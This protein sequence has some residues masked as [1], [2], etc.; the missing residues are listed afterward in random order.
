M[1]LVTKGGDLM[2]LNEKEIYLIKRRRLGITLQE[3]ADC[4]G[5][6]K[7]TL[8]RYENN[9]INFSLADKYKKYIDNK[10]NVLIK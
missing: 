9:L 2:H 5:V 7:G 1:Q 8:S 10:E 3:I 4:L 6:H